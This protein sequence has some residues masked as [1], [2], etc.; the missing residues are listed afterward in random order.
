MLAFQVLGPHG[1]F[2]K[3]QS[4]AKTV[5]KWVAPDQN[6]EQLK[7]KYKQGEWIRPTHFEQEKE[8]HM[9]CH[10]AEV[11]HLRSMLLCRNIVPKLSLSGPMQIRSLTW[12]KT[13]VTVLCE[14]WEKIEAWC[15][16][17]KFNTMGE[18]WPA[19]PS[20]HCNV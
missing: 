11:Q 14:D 3:K 4:V 20:K 8:G 15:K 16:N 1:Y 18:G 12:N 6:K 17:C 10:E 7:R 13:K 19:Q 2:F 9:Y 5:L